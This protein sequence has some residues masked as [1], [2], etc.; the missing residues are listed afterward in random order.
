M[1]NKIHSIILFSLF[2]LPIFAQKLKT[3]E[4]EYTYYAPETVSLE[5]AK[6]KALERAKIKA[7]EDAFNAVVSRYNTTQTTI[8]NGH[9]DSNFTSIG[10]SEVK[11]E[12]IETIG[13]PIYQ[14]AYEGNMLVVTVKVKGRAREINAASIDFKARILRNGTEDKF[15]SDNFR[16]G[17]DLYLSFTS[18]VAGYLAVYL[19]DSDNEAFCLLPYRNQANGIYPIEANHR[20]LFFNEKESPE[21]ERK[22]VDEYVMTCE[23]TTENNYI[24]V[25]FSPNQ[26]T[27]AADNNMDV[28]LPRQLSFEDF[29]KWLVKYRKM[30]QEMVVK[31]NPI[32]IQKRM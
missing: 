31:R 30:D 3:V 29:N 8:R 22:F 13:E 32:T 1:R 2:T 4:G 11:G 10:G 20:Y 19:V 25:I 9:T 16:A 18:P 14:T 7:V 15:E 21:S 27:K 26:F 5:E 12:W 6:R 23:R 24:Y 28:A 17:D